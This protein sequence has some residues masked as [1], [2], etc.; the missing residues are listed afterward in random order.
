MNAVNKYLI[1]FSHELTR[2]RSNLRV[3][4]PL[5]GK[6][7]DVVWLADQGHKVVGVELA[8][9]AIE[10]LF[11][12]NS[13]TF[14]VHSIKM[15]EIAEP[16]DVY[17]CNEKQITIFCCDLFR[18]TEEDVGGKFDAIWDRGS[19]S[20]I[21]PSLGDRGKLY[22]DKMHSFLSQDGRYLLES[23]RYDV[24]RQGKPPANI[25]QDHL[26]QMYQEKFFIKELD[27]NEL[28]PDP[29]RSL[30]FALALHYHLFTPKTN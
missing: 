7:L 30:T 8:K 10:G 21:A 9:Q 27:V 19:L 25:T 2:G 29:T 24:D 6:S 26:N 23:H 28:K 18:V 15:A 16:I 13:L 17:K 22:T 4:V 12:D 5:C 14:A 1:K 11:S 3:F 20:A